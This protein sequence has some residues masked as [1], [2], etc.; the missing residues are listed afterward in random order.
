VRRAVACGLAH[1]NLEGIEA[2]RFN[3]VA[4]YSGTIA[5][6]SIIA[7]SC[8]QWATASFCFTETRGTLFVSRKM[9]RCEVDT[10]CP[11]NLNS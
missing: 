7:G 10:P 11:A 4:A 2:I 1:R 9:Q 3:L 5:Q 8:M 6:R